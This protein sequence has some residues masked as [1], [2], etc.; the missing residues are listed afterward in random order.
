MKI[1]YNLD[2]K[3]GAA[4]LSSH[5]L[6]RDLKLN[7]KTAWYIMTRIRAEMAKKGGSLL[8]GI[9]EADETY[10][11][12]VNQRANTKEDTDQISVDIALKK[13]LYLARCS[14]V[15]KLLHNSLKFLNESVVI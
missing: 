15:G 14:A 10:I 2:K 8:Q 3:L 6:A 9:I 5:Q 4:T 11:G 12:G 7:Q 13:T 1:W